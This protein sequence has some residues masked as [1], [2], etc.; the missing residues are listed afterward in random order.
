MIE[1]ERERGEGSSRRYNRLIVFSYIWGLALLH[2]YS[3]KYDP[4]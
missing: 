1:R 4:R 2:V 3:N